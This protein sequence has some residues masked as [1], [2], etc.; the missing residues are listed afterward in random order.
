MQEKFEKY[1][2]DKRNQELYVRE[3]PDFIKGKILKKFQK[4]FCVKILGEY[5]FFGQKEL[6]EKTKRQ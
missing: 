1:A 5:E 2:A 3:T 4:K 6:I